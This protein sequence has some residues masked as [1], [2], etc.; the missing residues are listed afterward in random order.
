MFCRPIVTD[1]HVQQALSL[2]HSKRGTQQY[3]RAWARSLR[4]IEIKANQQRFM[5]EGKEIEETLAAIEQAV[6]DT[7]A[8]SH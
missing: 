2:A 4:L 7:E 6:G 5:S 8:A 3:N 1:V